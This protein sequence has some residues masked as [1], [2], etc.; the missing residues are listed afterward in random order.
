MP[1]Q[2]WKGSSS[3]LAWKLL[4]GLNAFCLHYKKD[5]VLVS[6]NINTSIST[7]ANAAHLTLPVFQTKDKVQ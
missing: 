1:A 6:I 2:I 4:V 3:T 7:N 5:L